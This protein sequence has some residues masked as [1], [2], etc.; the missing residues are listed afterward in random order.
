MR[1]PSTVLKNTLEL[2]DQRNYTSRSQ[3]M[4]SGLC[5]RS[6]LSLMFAI[7][8]KSLSSRFPTRRSR[9]HRTTM[10]TRP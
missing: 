3:A 10:F 5:S 2:C 6:I 9:S 8:L 7:E 1:N 4:K